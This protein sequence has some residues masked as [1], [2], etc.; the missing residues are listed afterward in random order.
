MVCYT[1]SAHPGRSVVAHRRTTDAEQVVQDRPDVALS[2][3]GFALPDVQ[4]NDASRLPGCLRWLHR[5]RKPVAAVEVD[6]TD[7]RL[8]RS[9][10]PVSPELG[11]ARIAT[12]LRVHP[13]VAGS[14]AG[15]AIDELADGAPRDDFVVPH[16][17]NFASPRVRTRWWA[18]QT[19]VPCLRA[20]GVQDRRA[21]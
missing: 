9:G 14:L 10:E 18:P 20:R 3:V 16:A 17:T 7:D 5:E 8:E 4:D 1:L 11:S 6:A 21:S 15:Q 13:L 12:E 19:R 2:A